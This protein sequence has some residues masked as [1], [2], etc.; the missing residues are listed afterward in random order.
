M[1]A[2]GA[3]MDTIALRAFVVALLLSLPHAALTQAQTPPA[4]PASASSQQPLTAAQLDALVAPI[5]LYPEAL[6]SA[7]TLPTD[8]GAGQ[9]AW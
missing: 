5:A 8:Q 7:V 4:Q 1:A 6:L 2:K 3:A 9:F